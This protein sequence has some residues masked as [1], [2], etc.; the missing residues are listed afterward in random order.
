MYSDYISKFLKEGDCPAD[1]KF[2]ESLDSSKMT[3]KW[4][5]HRSVGPSMME[6][7]CVMTNIKSTKE[8]EFVQAN[9]YLIGDSRLFIGDTEGRFDP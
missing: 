4:Y 9:D 5:W 7:N 3:G 6:M 8:N 2:F 1:I